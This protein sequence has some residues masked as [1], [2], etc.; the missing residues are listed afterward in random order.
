M[1]FCREGKVVITLDSP[2]SGIYRIRVSDTGVGIAPDRLEDI[3]D[4]FVQ[5]QISVSQ[6]HPGTGLGLAIA[7]K[8]VRRMGARSLSLSQVGSGSEFQV[9]VPLAICPPTP[10]LSSAQPPVIEGMRI[11]LAEDNNVNILVAT[12]ILQRAGCAVEVARD[13]MEAGRTG[14]DRSFDVV[15]MD[16]LRMPNLPGTEAA[17]SR[18]CSPARAGNT[19]RRLYLAMTANASP[20]DRAACEEAGMVGFLSKPFTYEQLIETLGAVAPVRV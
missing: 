20:E 14:H 11:L 7:R 12:A 10:A 9:V 16:L 5:A 17:V 19:C 8:L 6:E 13:G 4:E 2:E 3:F 15:L 1:K 18:F